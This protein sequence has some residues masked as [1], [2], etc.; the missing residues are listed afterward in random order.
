MRDYS[1][2]TDQNLDRRRND[3]ERLVQ[4][5]EH[6]APSDRALVCSIYKRGLTASELAQAIGTRPRTVRER[7]QRL[8]QRLN[9]PTFLYVLHRRHTWP[10]RRRRIAEAVFLRGECQRGVAAQMQVTVHVV[11]REA[12]RIRAIAEAQLLVN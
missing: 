8:V 6:L 2:S 5:A 7:V 11:R 10:L 3:S 12:E 9:S 4:L 1:Q